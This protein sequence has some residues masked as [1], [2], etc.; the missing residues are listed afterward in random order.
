MVISLIELVPSLDKREAMLEILQF[1]ESG[2]AR[3]PGCVGC[4]IYEGLDQDHTILYVEQWES[5][6][7]LHN[8]IRSSSYL[9]VLNQSTLAG[10]SQRLL[11]MKC[12]IRALWTSS[13]H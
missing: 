1:V 8:H 7:A 12:Q 10:L 13:K 6:Q 9:P 4:R 2:L 5:K 11:F 3:N